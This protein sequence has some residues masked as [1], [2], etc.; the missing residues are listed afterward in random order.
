MNSPI[1]IEKE[2]VMSWQDQAVYYF[3]VFLGLTSVT[4]F[5][6]WWFRPDHVPH[7]F[8]GIRHI[9]DFFL[10]T[11]LT[12]VVWTQIVNALF[13]WYCVYFM[14]K[15]KYLAPVERKKV[16]FLTAFVPGKEP[17]EI[18]QKTLQAM[19]EVEYPHETWLLDEGNTEEA[20]R[21]CRLYGV[22]HYSRKGIEKYN[23]PDGLFKAKTK[24]GNYNS[25]YD[26]NSHRYEFVAQID[27]DFVPKKIFLD[28]MLGYFRDPEVA[29]VGS[30]QIYGNTADSWIAQGAA[31]Q[32]Y[33]FYGSMQKGF[34]GMDMQLFIGANHIVR[35]KAHNGIG[36]YSGHIVEDHLTGMR[37]YAKKWKSVYVPE[38]L[39]IGEGPSTWDAYFGQQMRWSYGLMDILFRHSPKLFLHMRLRHI[40][41]YFLLQQYY[42]Y[43]FAQVLGIFLLTCYF[44][45]G[46][47]STSMSFRELLLIYPA[48]LAIQEIIFLWLQKFNINPE[49]ETGFML[50][51]KLLNFAA[52]PVYFVAFVEVVF[53][54]KLSYVITPKGKE[55]NPGMIQL[56]LFLPHFILG[57]I[58]FIEIII[59]SM[60]GNQA[61]QLLFWAYINTF[62]M[63]FFVLS[64]A[65]KASVVRLQ[66]PL[67]SLQK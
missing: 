25:W 1:R 54:K 65:I 51:G 10:F 8:P 9:F 49:K 28:R 41:N 21:L 15:P 6:L 20:K 60:T 56:N 17:Y 44:L 11:M 39:A 18:L 30:P 2:S 63:Y 33:A 45:L 12:Y 59:S 53:G 48:V 5:G 64:A 22:K 36:G 27:V 34:F 29:F 24:A 3:L 67:F 31:E 16:A 62:I 58:T 7:N 57:S 35:V 43:G 52:W 66:K 4:V 47:Q 13:F 37:F 38:I 40:L 42:F 61:L 19:V 50:H 46:I 23:K 32:A 55:Q 26:C 14:K